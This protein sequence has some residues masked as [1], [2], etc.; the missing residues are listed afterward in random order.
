MSLQFV[1]RHK[2]IS[3]VVAY[4][5]IGIVYAMTG[6]LHRIIIGKEVVFSPLVGIPLAATGWPMMVYADLKNIGIR[7]QDV[8]A[9]ISI[10]V[11]I[12]IF[13]KASRRG[14]RE[15]LAQTATQD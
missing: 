4:L 9:L 14:K 6:Y 10:F 5:V 2:T 12:M 8:S 13:V 1:K 3:I 15:G 11:F 7:P